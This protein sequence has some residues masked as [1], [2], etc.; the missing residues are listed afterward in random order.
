MLKSE[1]APVKSL[2]RFYTFDAFLH[3]GT[4]DIGVCLLG[5]VEVIDE[6][7]RLP[8]SWRRF[9]SADPI[10]PAP[11][12]VSYTSAVLVSPSDLWRCLSFGK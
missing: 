6:A 12:H 3:L 10:G 7:F 2:N 8:S 5:V 9:G 11:G 1:Y 4:V